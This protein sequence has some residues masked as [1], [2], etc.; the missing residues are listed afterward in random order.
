MPFSEIEAKLADLVREKYD[1]NITRE[2]ATH[3]LF[4]QHAELG[5]MRIG[6]P[7]AK[8]FTLEPVWNFFIEFNEHPDYSSSPDL[9]NAAYDGDPVFWNSLTISAIDGHVIDRD[10]GY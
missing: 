1:Y 8:T 6:K 9:L 5:L 10:R 3:E 7:N 4:I 2:D